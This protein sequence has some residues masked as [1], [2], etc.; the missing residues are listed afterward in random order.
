MTVHDCIQSHNTH[1]QYYHEQTCDYV[2]SLISHKNIHVLSSMEGHIDLSSS[3]LRVRVQGLSS[4]HFGFCGEFSSTPLA[5]SHIAIALDHSSF[6]VVVSSRVAHQN[7]TSV[8]SIG[9]S[10]VVVVYAQGKHSFSTLWNA[11]LP[12]WGHTL[13]KPYVLLLLARKL[14][15]TPG[16]HSPSTKAC[17]VA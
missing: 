2:H 1:K 8:I 11:V 15:R 10:L 12:R 5:R 7:W 6:L 4:V 16:S 9:G 3:S 13:G 14:V 17:Y